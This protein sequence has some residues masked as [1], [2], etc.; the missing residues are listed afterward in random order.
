MMGFFASLF[1]K[2]AL[3]RVGK[4]L[5]AIPGWVWIA[6]G[7]TV[8][9]GGAVY[10]HHR[11]VQA[12]YTAAYTAGVDDSEAMWQSKFDDMERE[13]AQWRERYETAALEISSEERA[14]HVAEIQSNA[15][16]ADDLRV[17]G[18]GAAACR[19]PASSAGLSTGTGG[20]D[21]FG[22]AADAAVAGVPA[23]GYAAVP[24]ADVVSFAELHDANRSEAL[25]WREWYARQ[26]ELLR[27]SKE[28]MTKR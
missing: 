4:F 15:A 18:P 21:T 11:A 8:L 14:R 16:R 1:A 17:H 9:L 28:A 5:K 2:L 27:Q 23:G 7:T 25:I 6:L 13:A 12:A 22:R 26:V 24:W 10:L 3:T 19:Q 20:D